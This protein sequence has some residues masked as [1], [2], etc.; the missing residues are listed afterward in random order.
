MPRIRI[1]ATF[2]RYVKAEKLKTKP[3]QGNVTNWSF[4]DACLLA[5]HCGW[6]I[7]RTSS[8]H[9]IFTHFRKEVPS[10]NL[11]E[12]TGQAKPYQLRQMKETIDTFK[13]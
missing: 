6:K 4:A 8:S 11:Q 5:G 3:L 1:H 13:L 12:K 7:T 9:H 2:S 10:L